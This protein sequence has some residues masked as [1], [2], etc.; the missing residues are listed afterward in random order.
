MDQ[1]TKKEVYNAYEFARKMV[2]KHHRDLI[3]NRVD[4]EIFRDDIHGKLSEIAVEKYIAENHPEYRINSGVDYSI[5][6]RGQWDISDL[7]INQ[8]NLNVKS[9][10]EKSSYLMIECQRYD[11]QGNYVYKNND[12]QPVKVDG[13]VLVKVVVKPEINED[14]FNKCFDIIDNQRSMDEFIKV[15][16]DDIGGRTITCEILG[17]I[18][19]EKFWEIKKYAPQGMMCTSN[20]LWRV[21]SG[22]ET[23]LLEMAQPWTPKNLK[24]QKDNYIVHKSRLSPLENIL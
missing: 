12:D 17:A 13:Y 23:S 14:D 1:F 7:I 24:L 18:D 22:V 4:W 16:K 21:V 11:D 5:M 10:G 19:H 9:I 15:F 8:K 20:N 6:D 2:G 3:M